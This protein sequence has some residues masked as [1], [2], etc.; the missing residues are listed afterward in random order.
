MFTMTGP[1]SP[2][3]FANMILDAE[4]H[5]DWIVD[6]MKHMRDNEFTRIE[7]TLVAEDAWVEHNQDVGEQSLRSQCQSWYLGANVPGK[8]RV[9]SPYIGGFPLYTQKLAEVIEGGY[10]GFD[11]SK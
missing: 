2:S 9:F 8:P 6:C 7:A 1:G 5:G 11:L 3:V 10:A 4:Q